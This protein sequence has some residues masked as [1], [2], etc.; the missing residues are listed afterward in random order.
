MQ[1][2]LIYCREAHAIDGDRPKFD[3][4]VEE[5]ISTEERLEVAKQFLADLDIQIPS[6][7][8][9]IDDKTGTDYAAHPDRM[10]LVG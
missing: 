2:F 8:D 5:P 6:L 9:K 4:T 7:L 10:Y 1:F 3:T